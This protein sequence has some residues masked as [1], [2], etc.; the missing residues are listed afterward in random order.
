MAIWR[1]Q[2]TIRTSLLLRS[3]ECV[4]SRTTTYVRDTFRLRI[5]LAHYDVGR[6]AAQSYRLW[7]D[8]VTVVTCG[9]DDVVL[10][11]VLIFD[12]SLQTATVYH[13]FCLICMSETENNWYAYHNVLFATVTA[14]TTD[15]IRGLHGG[16]LTSNYLCH[17]VFATYRVICD[18]KHNNC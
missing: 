9:H 6:S 1:G 17:L 2:A 4:G 14:G 11:P 15:E 13:R 12:F 8:D 3:M 18:E 7:S 5:I 10:S 16:I